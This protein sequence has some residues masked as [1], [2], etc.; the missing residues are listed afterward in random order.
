M[1]EDNLDKSRVWLGF[2]LLNF[3]PSPFRE[4]DG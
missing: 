3:A 2:R 4:A 1:K